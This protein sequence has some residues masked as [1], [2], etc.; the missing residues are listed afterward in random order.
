[1]RRIAITQRVCETSSFGERR[2]ALDQRWIEFLMSVDLLP[3]LLPNQLNC[4]QKILEENQ[5]DGILLTGGNSLIRY[6]GD[7][8]ERDKLEFFL[9]DWAMRKNVPLL[10]VCRGMQIIQDNFNNNLEQVSNHV[11]KRHILEV[12]QGCRLSDVVES[13]PD[14]NSFHDFGTREV[15]G[16]L[17]PVATSLDGI[18]M[19]VEHND[20]Q[21]FGV[22]WHSER[23]YPFRE[24]EKNLF[25]KVFYP[26]PT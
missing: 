6:G 16:K 2:D 23:E 5:I 24:Q 19:A 10:G 9:L 22:M 4:A 26:I 3:I 20:K 12:K 13:L 25:R 11:G 15:S 21:V 14:V 17:I 7:A 1:M 8:P 18:V